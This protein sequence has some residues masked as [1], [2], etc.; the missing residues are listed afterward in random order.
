MLRSL[1]LTLAL[2]ASLLTCVPVGLAQTP[3]TTSYE[4]VVS[5]GLRAYQAGQYPEA[6]ARF[7]RAHALSPSAR[8]LRALGMTA[9]ELRQYTAARSELE[10]ALA[11][12]RQP[13]TEAQRDE[14][15][16]MLTW[17]GSTLGTVRI[18]T[19]PSTARILIDGLAAAGRCM[20]EPGPHELR[21]EAEG[22]E[23]SEHRFD[24]TAGQER[25]FE[26]TLLRV[27]VAAVPPLTPATQLTA[28][29]Q[30]A[31]SVFAQPVS[32]PQDRSS[33]SVLEKWWFWTAI[34]VAVVAGTT[35]AVV[36]ASSGKQDLPAD[37]PGTK[38]QILLGGH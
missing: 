5:D 32:G 34:G 8:T 2:C 31:G 13:L 36:A 37:P 23:A 19:E 11:D 33:G 10:A 38:V 21:V 14:V 30:P 1:H 28:A 24:V 26:V 22:Y 25:S 17:M 7:E 4:Q 12:T 20:L 27:P 3:S 6:R 15:T 9:V 18:A 35:V 16:Q 29:S